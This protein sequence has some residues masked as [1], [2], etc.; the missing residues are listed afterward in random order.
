M[1]GRRGGGDEV[2]LAQAL[3]VGVAVYAGVEACIHIGVADGEHLGDLEEDIGHV[4][5]GIF[6]LGRDTAQGDGLI[7][8]AAAEI[9]VGQIGGERQMVGAAHVKA[10]DKLDGVMYICFRSLFDFSFSMSAAK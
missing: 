9:E 5:D 4:A 6:A 2:Y 3:Q 10:A 1:H 8:G 7:R